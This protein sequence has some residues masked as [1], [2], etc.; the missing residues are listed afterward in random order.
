MPFCFTTAGFVR[1]VDG[2]RRVHAQAASHERQM[3]TIL[4]KAYSDVALAVAALGEYPEDMQAGVDP[5]VM[6][7]R[8]ELRR[9]H[10]SV[11]TARRMLNAA[12]KNRLIASQLVSDLR[13]STA[14]EPSSTEPALRQAVLVVDDYAETREVVARMLEDAGFVVRTANNG[15][16]AII[17]AYEMKPAVIVMDVSMPVLNGLEATRLIKAI[18]TIRDVR[19]I[20]HTAEA[21]LPEAEAATLFAAVLHKPV[22]PTVVVDTVRRYAAV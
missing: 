8:A 2:A 6:A 21:H 3:E 20:A 15:L 9:S 11:A 14:T 18:D 1:I 13:D 7:L 10:D 22:P 5:L 4:T 19:V 16:Q 12:G 17:A